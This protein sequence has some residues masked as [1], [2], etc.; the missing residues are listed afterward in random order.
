M[1]T[2]SNEVA[3]SFPSAA[4]SVERCAGHPAANRKHPPTS[5]SLALPFI[6]RGYADPGWTGCRR[7]GLWRYL[8][9]GGDDVQGGSRRLGLQELERDRVPG[10]GRTRVRQARIP[11]ALPPAVRDQPHLLP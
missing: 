3:T 11:V 1:G 5:A 4:A 10:A 8:H 2:P 6:R 9:G 7:S